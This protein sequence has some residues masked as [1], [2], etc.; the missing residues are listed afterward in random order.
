[1]KINY[2][3]YLGLPEKAPESDIHRAYRKLM[4]EFHPDTLAKFSIEDENLRAKCK[5][6]TDL[7]SQ[8][9]SDLLS[10]PALKSF[11][12]YTLLNTKTTG[13]EFTI[14]AEARAEIKAH[15]EKQQPG[16]RDKARLDELIKKEKVQN[17]KVE[18]LEKELQ[19]MTLLLEASKRSHKALQDECN[20]Y[21]KRIAALDQKDK[22]I[23]NLEQ[24]NQALR[25]QLSYA[26]D[27]ISMLTNER[28]QFSFFQ[29]NQNKPS[30]LLRLG[31]KFSGPNI[32]R[33]QAIYKSIAKP[34]VDLYGKRY[35]T[36]FHEVF[37]VFENK[38]QKDIFLAMHIAMKNKIINALPEQERMISLELCFDNRADDALAIWARS[39]AFWGLL[40][41]CNDRTE[42]YV[43]NQGNY[44]MP[45]LREL[46]DLDN[47]LEFFI[48]RSLFHTQRSRCFINADT[49]DKATKTEK[50]IEKII[51]L[52][53]YY[54]HSLDDRIA[55]YAQEL[56]THYI[57]PQNTNQPMSSL[58]YTPSHS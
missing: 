46:F 1:M 9:H 19:Q 21:A 16:F 12:D 6:I 8:L 27:K 40:Q 38:E 47:A 44:L 15:K 3:T 52:T 17:E 20:N 58:I 45:L 39:T 54:T 31:S 43:K 30:T 23:D 10:S 4:L 11:Y 25:F 24:E 13:I 7:L 42:R 29:K 50:T 53:E 49:L 33:I 18:T 28:K 2:Y 56:T 35:D 14:L 37:F 32:P 26:H 48:D 57:I 36:G 5:S 22:Q 34:G 51:K 41:S 55:Q